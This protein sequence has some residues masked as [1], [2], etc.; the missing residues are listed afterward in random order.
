MRRVFWS[1]IAP[2]GTVLAGIAVVCLAA[3]PHCFFQQQNRTVQIDGV[4]AEGAGVFSNDSSWNE[5]V[6]VPNKD[7]AGHTIYSAD[8][9]GEVA[10]LLNKTDTIRLPRMVVVR[11]A[12][13]FSNLVEKEIYDPS[14]KPGDLPQRF[15]FVA[16]ARR[17]D[18]SFRSL[19][20]QPGVRWPPG[21]STLLLGF[22]AAWLLLAPIV[23]LGAGWWSLKRQSDPT[24]ASRGKLLSYVLLFASISWLGFVVTAIVDTLLQRRYDQRVAFLNHVGT[25]RGLWTVEIWLGVLGGIACILASLAGRGSSRRSAIYASVALLL[26]WFFVGIIPG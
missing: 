18:V 2:V 14:L 13:R 4:V 25:M 11:D 7:G 10:G 1:W 6:V 19:G 23:F 16:D 5:L 12:S 15:H 3:Y 20:R 8:L 26:M 21:A 24:V 17:V 9:Q 22:L